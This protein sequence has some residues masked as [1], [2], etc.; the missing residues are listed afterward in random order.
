MAIADLAVKQWHGAGPTKDTVTTPRLS[1]MDDD[2]PGTA[3]PIP[4]KESGIA[5]SFW[6]TLHLTITDIH[7]ATVL[8]N[9]KFFM[10]GACGWA[11]GTAGDLFIGKKSTGDDGVPGASYDRATGEVGVDGDDMN[12]VTDGHAYY[13]TGSSDYNAPVASDSFT[14]VAPMTVDS[15]EHTIAEEFKGVVLQ[16]EVDDDAV[17]G[18]QAAETLTFQ[19]DEV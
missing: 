5:F 13:K 10:D 14:S 8:N 6:M 11:L 19:Y 9:H 2:A 3:N 17:R 1:T 18:A 16:V 15:G 7:E 12:D 4:I